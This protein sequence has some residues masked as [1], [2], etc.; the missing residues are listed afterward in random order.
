[1]KIVIIDGFTLFSDDLDWHIFEQFGEVI[2]HDRTPSDLI[3]ERSKNAQI[4]LNNKVPFSEKTINQLPDLQMIG[5]FATGYNVIDTKATASRNITVCNVPGYGTNS[6]A[7][8]AFALLLELSNHAGKN[9]QSVANGDWVSAKD[10]CYTR[11]PIIELAGKTLGIVGFGN[12]GQQMANIGNAF[13]MKV[14]YY[15]RSSKNHGFAAEKGLEELFEESDFISLNCP[16]TSDNQHFV[17]YDLLSKMKKTAFLINTSRGA[18]IEETDLANALNEGLLAGA[19][20]DV[21]SN[22]PPLA[23]SPL[24]NAKNCIITPHNAWISLEARQRIMDVTIE[25]IKAFLGGKA[26]N[27]V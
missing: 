16:L 8:H 19:G 11:S 14:I 27:I 5:M 24:L 10:W 25:N 17:N 22:E 2:Y 7:Q 18:L 23:N 21:L 13:G 6:V 3:V 20:L 9:A 12:I 15:S 26:I 4:I 1:M